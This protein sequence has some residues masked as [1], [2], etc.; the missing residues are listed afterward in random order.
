MR[1]RR[2]TVLL[3]ACLL[4]ALAIP[5]SAADRVALVV[6]N[7]DY[8]HAPR[9]ANP[10]NDAADTAAALARLDFAV[11]RLDN[12]SKATL[13]QALHRLSQAATGSEIALVFYAGH[14]IEVDKRNVLV[15]VVARLMSDQD[16]EFETVSL[17]LVMRAVGRASDIG[18]FL[19]ACRENPF[20]ASMQRSGA[21]RAIGRG[22][23]RVKPS[24][25]TMVAYAA[26]EGEVAS[27][28]GNGRNS[29]YTSALLAHLEEQGLE[30]GL[31]FRRVRDMVLATTRGKQVPFTY[32]SVSGR[33]IYFKA[34]LPDDE[35]PAE[36]RAYIETYPRG[37]YTALARNR[38]RG[39]GKLAL[40]AVDTGNL[41]EFLGRELSASA[42]DDNGWTDLHY[43]V[44]A[45]LPEVAEAL[46]D[47]GADPAAAGGS[48]YAG[49][50]LGRLLQSLGF[51]GDFWWTT[52][53][54]GK[55][56][57][58]LHMAALRNAR[59]AALVLIKRD[60]NVNAQQGSGRT[61]LHWAALNDAREIALEL[62]EQGADFRARDDEGATPLHYAARGNAGETVLELIHR[63][64]DIHA[65]TMYD[66]T[67]LHFAALGNAREI[68]L[69][70]IER[71]ADITV[72]DD[73]GQTPRGVARKEARDDVEALLGEA[74]R[75]I[76]SG[77][78]AEGFDPGPADG[79][80][81]ERTR[82]A[83]ERQEDE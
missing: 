80:I 27:D 32:G 46:L 20:V 18:R 44:A 3:A 9:L 14:G 62:I 76:Q 13:E 29:P 12:A 38:L 41:H 64:S 57:T 59:K 16:V 71:G 78:A 22:L 39:P 7:A 31:M 68:A 58:P 65:R 49:D 43:A 33:G 24:G 45:N 83:Q 35:D 37:R 50:A 61:P 66:R 81:G 15:P 72:T 19:D 17:D 23:A 52:F 56:F 79:W 70:L 53:P 8:A 5:V 67:P 77:L 4:L 30:V 75:W 54:P 10:L 69:E 82:A 6:G 2:F 34:A 25:G 26:A 21:N 36:L 51:E 42:V 40:L 73:A 28:D 11:T 60:A 74:S 48:L 1:I 55:G 47:T 63:G